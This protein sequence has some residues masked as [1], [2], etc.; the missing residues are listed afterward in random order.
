M[1]ELGMSV[2]KTLKCSKYG[3]VVV[4]DTTKCSNCSSAYDNDEIERMVGTDDRKFLQP[5]MTKVDIQIT[6]AYYQ[7]VCPKHGKSNVKAA[8]TAPAIRCS[9]A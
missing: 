4:P 3:C 6:T 9:L 1:A 8:I 2:E 5:K 7:F